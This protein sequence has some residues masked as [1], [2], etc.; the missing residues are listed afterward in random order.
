MNIRIVNLT[1]KFGSQVLFD[2]ISFEIKHDVTVLKGASGSGKT[3]ILRMLAGLD[4]DY[5]GLIEGV[6][7]PVSYLFQEDRLMPWFNVEKNIA[8]ALRDVMDKSTSAQTV[9]RIIRDVQLDGHEKKLPAELSGGMQRRVAMARAF[10]H[11]SQLLLMD[12]P[13]KG[14]DEKLMRELLSLFLKL[15]RDTQKT[16]VLVTHEAW[17]IEQLECDVIDVDTL[18]HRTVS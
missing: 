3:T 17:L 11:P 16:V 10:C 2:R 18:S 6:P 5:Q 15:I 7:R 12:E 8:F 1:K 14:F 9:R 13:F 4:N